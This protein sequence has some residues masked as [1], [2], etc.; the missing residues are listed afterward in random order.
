MPYA[1]ETLPQLI[2]STQADIQSRLSGVDPWLPFSDLQILAYVFAAMSYT[3]YGYLDYISLNAVPVTA[4]QEN[5]EAW[6]ALKG[7]TRIAAQ[8]A[9]GTITFSGNVGVV[10]SEFTEVVRSDGVG[11]I[12]PQGHG[13]T[14]GMDGTF[15]TIATAIDGG[16][17]TNLIAGGSLA[18]F[19][20]I[21]GVNPTVIVT[22]DFTGGTDIE[23]DDSL[24]NRMIFA[25]SHPV[26]GGNLDDYVSWMLQLPQVTR[27]WAVGPYHYG[28]GTVT[29]YFM[30]DITRFAESGIP[31]GTNGASQFE[32][33]LFHATGDQLTIA[34]HLYPLR[35]ATALIFVQ[36]PVGV[37]LNLE[38]SGVPADATIQ[39]ACREALRSVILRTA[40]PVGVLRPDD[41]YGG[42]VYLSDIEDA[43]AA[44][45]GVDHFVIL[46]PTNDVVLPNPGEIS[47]PGTIFFV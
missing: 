18:L 21:A 31:Q 40:V 39:A 6:A 2:N 15:T 17:N 22:A 24:R 47:I 34:N 4:I 42:V 9:T 1:R 38:I 28:P 29:A 43:I 36:A 19:G 41:T 14:I 16:L 37:A 25:F 35:S 46:Q 27:A 33:R 12:V 10:V 23:G 20:P 44:V 26:Q 8:P 13:G 5:L 32:E 11:Y 3:R 30:E 7:I 45:P